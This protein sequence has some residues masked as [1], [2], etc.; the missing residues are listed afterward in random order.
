MGCEFVI[1]GKSSSHIYIIYAIWNDIE[2]YVWPLEM[3]FRPEANYF[4]L[5]FIMFTENYKLK[6]VW[7]IAFFVFILYHNIWGY[8]TLTF[9]NY[10]WQL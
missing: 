2:R 3:F 5:F 4:I 7:N 8:Q 1:S 9:E 10:R 6:V